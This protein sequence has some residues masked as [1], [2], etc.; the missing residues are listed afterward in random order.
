MGREFKDHL[1]TLIDANGGIGAPNLGRISKGLR[2]FEETFTLQRLRGLLGGL[3]PAQ[4][5]R[6]AI[7]GV[8]EPESE[9]WLSEIWLLEDEESRRLAKFAFDQTKNYVRAEGFADWV[10]EKTRFRNADLSDDEIRNLYGEYRGS[11]EPKMGLE[12]EIELF[13]LKV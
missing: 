2:S 6:Q 13:D 4:G 12:E 5:E 1:K 9:R 10:H 8:L 11:R 7:S 3:P